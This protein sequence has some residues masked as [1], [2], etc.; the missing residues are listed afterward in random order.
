VPDP[1][2]PPRPS[3][4]VSRVRDAL[5]GGRRNLQADRDLADLL[6][7]RFPG[8]EQAAGEARAF[9]G[10]AV[11]WCARQGIAQFIVPEP[12]LPL[13][14]GAAEAARA[15]IP[16]ARVAYAVTDLS[17]I[18][19]ARAEAAR[20]DATAAVL[21]ISA[22]DPAGLLADPALLTVIDLGEPAAVVL[23]M[24]ACLMPGQ[25]AAAMVAGYA[26]RLAPGSAL[27]VS[28]W[29][30]HP[31]PGA[32]RLIA[33]CAPAVEVFRHTVPGIE[34]WL[35]GLDLVKPGVTDVRGW[36]AEM[37]EPRLAPRPAGM[38]T[39]GAVARVP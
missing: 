37:P 14:G 7:L 5:L 4:S 23:A 8:T 22:D 13:P 20:D 15:V 27:V 35:R 30:P 31:G 1:A 29:V 18:G 2:A 32:D 33:A 36:R 9:V 19:Y 11:T 10:R 34:G 24:T 12:G 26:A 25:E 6:E 16:G 28:A 21:G 39:A 3:P 17:E 38:M